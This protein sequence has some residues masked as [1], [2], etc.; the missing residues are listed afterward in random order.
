MN[1]QLAGMTQAECTTAK[2]DITV[3]DDG[4]Y[5]KFVEAKQDKKYWSSTTSNKVEIGG[6]EVSADSVEITNSGWTIK[7]TK[8][9]EVSFTEGTKASS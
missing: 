4:S 3:A 6:K 1:A 7:V 8:D 5:S 9:G 2:N